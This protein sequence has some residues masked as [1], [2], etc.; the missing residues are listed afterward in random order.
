MEGRAIRRKTLTMLAMTSGAFAA[1]RPVTHASAL[2]PRLEQRA[3]AQ[4]SLIAR[5][6]APLA[7][8]SIFSRD[9]ARARYTA[10]T[11]RPQPRTS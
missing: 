4:N 3:A 9:P 6:H 8:I 2:S 7:A 10:Y 5:L 1:A 11:R